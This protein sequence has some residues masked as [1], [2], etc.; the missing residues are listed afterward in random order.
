MNWKTRMKLHCLKRVFALAVVLTS[1]S[2]H[3]QNYSI[4]WFTVDG[5]GGISAGGAYSMSGTVGQPDAGV[6]T[7]GNFAIA[8]GFWSVEEINLPTLFITRSG[9]NA[10]ISWTPGSPGFVLQGNGGFSP[11]G[12]ADA[13]SGSTNPATVPA[14]GA[15]RFYR[16]RK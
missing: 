1:V 4:D 13:P 15:A 10:I 12:W 2:V 7:G 14:A 9:P 5:G 16:L 8:G 6:M 11:A 3:A